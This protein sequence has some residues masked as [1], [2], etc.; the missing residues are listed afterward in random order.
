MYF[1]HD[2]PDKMIKRK[3][4]FIC[5]L[6]PLLVATCIKEHE[7]S[8]NRAGARGR[9]PE[10]IRTEGRETIS[11][12]VLPF[13]L[14]E[15]K[16]LDGPFL[17]ATVLN[18][19]NLLGYEP[20]RLLAGF[21]QEA[22]LKPK[23][24]QY[25]GW[26]AETL[27]GHS[28][29]H[30]L[31]ALSMMYLT[32]GQE[33]FRNRVMYIV[34][35]LKKC[36]DARGS[37]YI[38]AS[39]GARKI[40]E[41]EVA[42]GDIRSGSFDLNGIW[43]PFYT[44]HKILAGLRDAYHFCDDTSA[45]EIS[46]RFADWIF[47]VVD[48]LSP[49]QIEDMLHCEYGGMLEVLSDLYADTGNEKYLSMTHCFQDKFILEPLSEGKDILPGKHGNTNIPKLTGLARRYELTGDTADRKTAEFFWETVTRHHSYVTGGNGNREYFGD[50]DMLRDAL[51]DETTETCNVY[52]MLKLT[53]HLFEWSASPEVADFYERA[54]FNHILASQH[55]DSGRVVYNLSLKMGGYKAFQDPE[56]FTCCI[57]TGMENH[58][59]YGGSIYYHN[60]S[61][62]YVSQFIASELTW[63]EKGL[64]VTQLTGYPEEQGTTLEFNADKP[65]PL[66]VNI[67]YPSWATKGIKILVNGRSIDIR[68]KRG[69]FIPITSRWKTGDRIEVNLPF[70]LRLEDMPDDSLRVA[71][72]NGPVLLAGVLGPVDDPAAGDSLYVPVMM[73]SDREP[74]HWTLPVA[75][76]TGTFMTDATGYPRDVL[77]KPFYMTYDV[78]YSVFWD[79]LPGEVP[80]KDGE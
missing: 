37:G 39:P 11:F 38:G 34:G 74:A 30:Y 42:A 80:G 19:M 53:E 1:M 43:A 69:S 17:N 78:R 48:D 3:T 58:A 4:I 44:E 18:S 65:V 6:C 47:T 7:D 62:L 23:A 71:V 16:L 13:R 56:W 15:V 79:M 32:T 35:E 24:K 33:A 70:E 25:G 51:G 41:E 27:A 5:M 46:E 49:E 72:F 8:G 63:K 50:P 67:R 26:E 57:G 9:T 21:R 64:T 31:S 60:E 12:R 77:M 36:Q 68:N 73:T 20:D 66:T 2:L 54:L 61:E 76:K 75:N 29:G 10:S 22:G 52:N 45:L 40:L 59:K 28:L 55:P 14:D